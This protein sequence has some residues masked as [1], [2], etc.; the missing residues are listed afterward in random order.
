VGLDYGQD[1]GRILITNG[2][3]PALWRDTIIRNVDKEQ[4]AMS[5][6]AFAFAGMPNLADLAMSGLHGLTKTIGING[7]AANLEFHMRTNPLTAVVNSAM[8]T[9]EDI[10]FY[11]L[12]INDDLTFMTMPYHAMLLPGG[13]L[14]SNSWHFLDAIKSTV[15]F[16]VKAATGGTVKH[17]PNVGK[18]HPSEPPLL[19]GKV[20]V[21]L[22]MVFGMRDGY[23]KG[24]IFASPELVSRYIDPSVQN[25]FRVTSIA[26]GSHWIP[27][28]KPED[29]VSE[30]KNLIKDT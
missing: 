15:S 1:I 25:Q 2:P 29:L 20:K 21:P 27:E 26:D 13:P 23:V 18:S 9:P 5:W 14:A 10:R 11:E 28:E 4:F 8:I 16:G 24:E 19:F 22:R 6:Y 3:Q 17:A 30:I 7:I 12:A